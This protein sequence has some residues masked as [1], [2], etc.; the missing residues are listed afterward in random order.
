MR[1][2]DRD[3]DGSV[4]SVR[5][6][7]TERRS[8]IEDGIIAHTHAVSDLPASVDAEYPARLRATVTAVVDYGL[9][10]IQ[11]GE[12]WLGP[13]PSAVVAQ[14]HRAAR[15]GTRLETVLLCYVAGN[16]LVADFVLA[17]ADQFP[18]R[19]LR[20]V[21]NL[22]ALLLERLMVAISIEYKR[23]A[24]RAGRSSEQRHAQLVRKL[25]G[26]ETVHTT[27]VGYDFDAWHLGVIAAG[28]SARDALQGLAASADRRL[29][30]VQQGDGTVW[31]W[32]GGKGRLAAEEIDRL[33]VKE[34]AGV[35]MAV[36]EPGRG[37]DGWRLTH[38]QAQAAL[39][40]SLHRPRR[41]T[42]YAEEMLVAAALRDETL[43]KSLS[44]IYLS[45]LVNQ[46]D[47]GMVSLETLRAYFKV[48]RN[49][50]SAGAEIGVA[51]QTIDQRLLTVEQ[52]L[53]RALPTCLIELEV[54]LRLEELL[55]SS[56]ST[57]SST[58]L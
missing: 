21:L 36:G 39:L 35:S 33:L 47:R 26:G 10:G 52:V 48:R 42:L 25:L 38:H 19:A 7:L 41:I 30:H 29:L 57:K 13:I 37:I 31:A 23:E 9:M 49:A 17:E 55:G 8:E 56:V 18:A 5:A 53:G 4:E 27:K 2:G 58:V 44:Q 1:R 15:N 50:S 12:E 24:E 11:H 6:Y 32:L 16:R 45:P 20:R 3:H 40:V 51:R 46:R 43:A 14:A 54:A 34:F 28:D 22:Q